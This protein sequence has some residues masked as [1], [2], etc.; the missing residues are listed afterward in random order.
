MFAMVPVLLEEL[1]TALK[2]R[3]EGTTRVARVRDVAVRVLEH[4]DGGMTVVL[5]FVLADPPDGMETWPVE[6]LW[7][8]RRVAREIVPGTVARVVQEAALEAGIAVD[9]LPTFS[10]TVE[11]KPEHMPPLAADDESIAFEG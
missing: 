6:E 11:F 7:E 5:T 4:D 8:L 9:A 1:P 2:S 3:A 10:W